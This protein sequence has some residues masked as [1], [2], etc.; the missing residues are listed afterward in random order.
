MGVSA[1]VCLCVCVERERDHKDE[2]ESTK[3]NEEIRIL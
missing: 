3:H 1:R 2:G